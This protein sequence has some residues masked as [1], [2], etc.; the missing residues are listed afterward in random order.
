MDKVIGG[1]FSVESSLLDN[2]EI[3]ID[4]QYSSGRCALA[5]ILNH[6]KGIFPEVST[7]LLP[8]Y[9]CDSITKTVIDSGWEYKFYNIG[10]DLLPY[11]KDINDLKRVD[12]L[13]VINYFGLLNLDEFIQDSK[14]IN[15]GLIVI[16]DD[17]QAYYS[18]SKSTADYSF[19]SLRKWFPCPDGA[20]VKSKD[21]MKPYISSYSKW[22]EYKFA[23]NM[24]KSCGGLVD[25]SICLNLLSIGEELLDK[26]YLSLCSEASKII[27]SNIKFDEVANK[28]KNNAKIL[29]DSL[30]LMGIK[31]LYLE[32]SVPLF[33]PIFVNNRDK[34]RKEYFRNCIFTPIHWPKVSNEI[35][36]CSDLY[37]RELSLICDQRYNSDDMLKQINVL[38]HFIDN[39]GI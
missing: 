10:D 15:P 4:I 1:E 23:G 7:I 11:F 8:N 33:I 6:I 3:K 27:F 13:F 9:L 28:R 34:L 19:T 37:D 20:L 21:K 2:K 14:R 24:L 30:S 22:S 32:D 18:Y 31:H 29:H 12:S 25:D 38:K 39:E 36:E 35:N 16:E 5:A 17:V 26:E